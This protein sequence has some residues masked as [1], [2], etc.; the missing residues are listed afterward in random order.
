MGTMR[1]TVVSILLAFFIALQ[2]AVCLEPENLETA[3][4]DQAVEDDPYGLMYDSNEKLIENLE[5]M[6]DLLDDA[7]PEAYSAEEDGTKK[8][9]RFHTEPKG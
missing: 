8:R 9:Q 1:K 7:E 3:F 6:P 5:Q 2:P 4:P